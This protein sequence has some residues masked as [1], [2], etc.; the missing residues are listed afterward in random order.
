M[1][2]TSKF[3]PVRRTEIL[4][5][6]SQTS[7]QSLQERMH[8]LISIFSAE[9]ASAHDVHIV[10]QNMVCRTAVARASFGFPRTSGCSAIILATDIGTS[11]GAIAQIARWHRT[12]RCLCVVNS[13]EWNNG[14]APQGALS[15]HL[16]L[17]KKSTF[18]RA[19]GSAGALL[20]FF[21]AL[22][23]HF[24][25]LVFHRPVLLI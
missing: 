24:K 23:T 11:M 3:W 25:E 18:E 12:P 1:S 14:S 21:K 10:A 22:E 9:H 13:G 8:C 5:V 19:Q 4:D 15:R 20:P 7:A 2:T 16:H 17:R 6:A